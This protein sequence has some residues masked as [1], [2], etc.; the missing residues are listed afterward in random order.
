[1]GVGRLQLRD[2]TLDSHHESRFEPDCT[3]LRSLARQTNNYSFTQHSYFPET[4]HPAVCSAGEVRIDNQSQACPRVYQHGDRSK[5]KHPR[6]QCSSPSFLRLYPLFIPSK[7]IQVTFLHANS[8]KCKGK[9][10]TS[11]LVAGTAGPT[12][13][14]LREWYIKNDCLPSVSYGRVPCPGRESLGT[15]GHAL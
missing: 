11:E 15:R 7:Y 8:W 10:S 6:I 3:S 5:S 9:D 14:E 12:K 13:G 1:M 2:D 4:L